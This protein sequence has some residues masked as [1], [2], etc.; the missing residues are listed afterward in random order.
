LAGS[1][2]LFVL[3]AIAMH[4]SRKIKWY[5]PDDEKE[6]AIIETKS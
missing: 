6:A 3:V 1:I 2:G 5:A 4:L